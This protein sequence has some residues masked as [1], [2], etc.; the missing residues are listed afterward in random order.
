MGI[1]KK[2]KNLYNTL[3]NFRGVSLPHFKLEQMKVFAINPPLSR[4]SE[5]YFPIALKDSFTTYDFNERKIITP[6]G[7][8][9]PAW[10]PL[11]H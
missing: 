5:V 10:S 6:L 1:F 4:V 11:M 8:S 3:I 2:K 7:G 9:D